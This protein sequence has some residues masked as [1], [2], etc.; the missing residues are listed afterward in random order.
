M[1][2]REFFKGAIAFAASGYFFKARSESG[3]F[4]QLYPYGKFGAT[5]GPL[6]A[7][8]IARPVDQDD[9]LAKL[10]LISEGNPLVQAR[11][12]VKFGAIAA[13]L[14]EWR[15][16][17]SLMQLRNQLNHFAPHRSKVNDGFIGDLS[18]QGR[19]SDHNPWVL[20]GKIG[21]VTA[22]DITHDPKGGCGGETIAEGLVKPK[23]KRIKYIIWNRQI[24]NSEAVGSSA[25]WTWREY[26]GISPHTE[27][28]HLSVL[29]VIA[30][31]DSGEIWQLGLKAP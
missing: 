8:D 24:I 17:E 2:K 7:G 15:V 10:E 19:Q 4:H 21:V 30:L 25:P 11:E 1:N 16:A 5:S 23:D 6:Q 12:H 27:H 26:R 9:D 3:N 29:P 18:H 13:S 20:D 22:F 31:Y 14:R 28:V